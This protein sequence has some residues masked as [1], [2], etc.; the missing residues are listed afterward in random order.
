MPFLDERLPISPGH[1][2]NAV[3]YP[4]IL[5]PEYHPTSPTWNI[6]PPRKPSIQGDFSFGTQVEAHSPGEKH[7][8][9][10]RTLKKLK[11]AVTRTRPTDNMSTSR[12][13]DVSQHQKV[14]NPTQNTAKPADSSL[15][16]APRRGPASMRQP[17]TTVDARVQLRP[18]SPQPWVPANA[19]QGH[20][21]QRIAT[22]RL[23]SHLNMLA[24]A[25]PGIPIWTDSQP[26][27]TA[28]PVVKNGEARRA[29][30]KERL[31]ISQWEFE[32]EM[33]F[34]RCYA[35]TLKLEHL[36]RTRRK[37]EQD[38]ALMRLVD[39]LDPFLQEQGQLA[40]I[41]ELL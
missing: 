22:Q 37:A 7:S 10:A 26:T 32:A 15:H 3:V 31:K 13:P 21:L 2:W 33:A 28:P 6:K 35:K 17:S 11:Q 34:Q 1:V 25:G 18:T 8:P 23:Q 16:P 41:R 4:L 5:V 12:N 40:S 27:P 19:R 30:A 9:L 36:E 38:C 24:P 20:T 14:Q 29:T 39:A